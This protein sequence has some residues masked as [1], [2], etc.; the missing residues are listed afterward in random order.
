MRATQLI[1]KNEK[2][3][4]EKQVEI[5]FKELVELTKDIPLGLNERVDRI[6][7]IRTKTYE[8][9]NQL[10]HRNLLIRIVEHFVSQQVDISL[11]TWHPEQSSDENFA[12]ITGFKV[13][14]VIFNIEATTSSKPIGKPRLQMK[15]TLA[16]L[17]SKQGKKYYFVQT[18]EMYNSALRTVNTENYDITVERI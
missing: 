18:T 5:F 3:Q 12:D 16:S 10:Q 9:I 13:D 1:I 17:N 4:L 15:K 7:L 8:K 6:N 14:K 11:W 2:E